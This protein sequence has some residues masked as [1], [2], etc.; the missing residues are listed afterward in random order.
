M[1]VAVLGSAFMLMVYTDVVVAY[2]AHEGLPVATSEE[3]ARAV[4]ELE[5]WAA[6]LSD[7]QWR[8]YLASLP[9]AT[10]RAYGEIVAQ[11]YVTG[12]RSVL[13]I[14]LGVV[15]VMLLVSSWLKPPEARG[16]T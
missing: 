3:R 12:Y 7:E 6:K 10:A 16:E 15:G 13:R 8:A 14:L 11:A 9:E 4:V 5:D 2:D 1:G